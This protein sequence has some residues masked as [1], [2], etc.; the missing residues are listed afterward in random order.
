MAEEADWQAVRSL[1]SELH[2]SGP[3]GLAWEV[4]RWDGQRFHRADH[5]SFLEVW[6]ERVHLWWEGDVLVGAVHPEGPGE[7][8]FQLRPT[9]RH[10]QAEMLD[11]A[12]T[13]LP[14]EGRI[15]VFCVD[16]DAHLRR[17]LDERGFTDAGWGGVA[18]L[19]TMSP[20]APL[21]PSIAA[22]YR[23]RH[24][25]PEET[26][27]V[28]SL[29]SVAFGGRGDITEDLAAFT[30]HAPCFVREWDLVAEATDGSLAAYVGV[31]WDHDGDLGIFEPVCTHPDHQRRGLAKALMQHGLGLLHARGVGRACVD[32]GDPAAANALYE[33]VGFTEAYHGRAFALTTST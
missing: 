4:R 8:F 20:H 10:L 7:A 15:T 16:H 18:R 28:A 27:A 25:T 9:H 14:H 31:S 22:G 17:L 6:S 26:G 12:I 33:S 5:D 11:W 29:I 24:T 1:I 21:P 13:H 19:L 3:P 2:A 23:I 30:A 32:S